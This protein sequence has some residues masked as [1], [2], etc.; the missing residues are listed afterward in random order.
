MRRLACLL[1]AFV[2]YSGA[3]RGDITCVTGPAPGAECVLGADGVHLSY[4]AIDRIS[5]AASRSHELERQVAALVTA[6]DARSRE[7]TALRAQISDMKASS[8]VSDEAAKR[9]SEALA[10]SEQALASE[11]SSLL[12]NPILMLGIGGALGAT[13]MYL[14]VM[15]AR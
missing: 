5:K 14:V 7:A 11:R 2:A 10:A 4:D 3:A 8:V 13:A 9:Q 15:A 12:R 6:N 1:T